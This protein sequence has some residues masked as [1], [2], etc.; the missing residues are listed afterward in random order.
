MKLSERIEIVQGDITEER[1]DAIVNAAN[2]QLMLGFGVAGAIR[3]KGGRSIQE[4]CD[5]QAPV[6][7]G[8]AAL[9]DGGE[10]NARYVIHAA[11]M[12]LGG[13]PTEDSIQLATTNSLVIAYEHKFDVVSFPAIG[14]GIGGF[15]M[16]KAAEIMLGITTGFLVERE[17]PRKVR[18]VLFDSKAFQEFE[19]TWNGIRNRLPQS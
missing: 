4:E 14:T 16:E 19:R 15:S 10:L 3:M 18:F 8:E 11:G 7:L 1:V 9:T 5:E 13:H 6:E 17:Y 12:R 2:T